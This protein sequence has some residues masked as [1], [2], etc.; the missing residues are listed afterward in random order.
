M[1]I[2]IL[3]KEILALSEQ[4]RSELLHRV[5]DAQIPPIPVGEET[6]SVSEALRRK[7]EMEQ[8]PSIGVTWETI[9]ANLGRA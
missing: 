6:D 4:E 7:N 3:E 9:K 1:T 8:D 2:D 5:A